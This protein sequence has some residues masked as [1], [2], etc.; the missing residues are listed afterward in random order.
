MTRQKQQAIE[1]MKKMNID[2]KYINAF[3]EEDKVSLFGV[4]GK[5]FE[6]EPD[7]L[8]YKKLKAV[9]AER[10]CLVYAVT[11]DLMSFGECFSYL[12]VSPYEEDW[13]VTVRGTSS[14]YAVIAYVENVQED[15]RSESGYIAVESENGIIKRIG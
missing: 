4:F 13:S 7:S 10:N 6:I 1:Y 2:P 9:E 3:A 8:F 12:Y 15:W 5:V 11:H 14:P